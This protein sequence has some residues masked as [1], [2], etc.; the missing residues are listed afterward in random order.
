MIGRPGL[1]QPLPDEHRPI[2]RPLRIQEPRK[3][4]ETLR[5]E[6]LC[7]SLVEDTMKTE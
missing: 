5:D 6:T 7:E 2:K 1:Q 4:D 3:S